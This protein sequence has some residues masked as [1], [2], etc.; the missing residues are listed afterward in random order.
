MFWVFS[1]ISLQAVLGAMDN[2]WHHE[3]TE[4]LPSRRSAARE[5]ALHAAR[6]SIYALIFIA[7]AWFQWQGY[8]ALLI[9]SVMV[10]EILITT[11]DFVVEDQT[12]RLPAF[13]RVCTPSSR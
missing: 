3:I 2:L 12:R 8:W 10:L 5:L 1:L 4:R 9:A 7:L 11:V 6:E 13:E